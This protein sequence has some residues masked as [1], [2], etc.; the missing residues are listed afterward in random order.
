MWKQKIA[1]LQIPYTH[2][3][4]DDKIVS[5]LKEILSAST[6]FPAHVVTDV[7]GK[8]NSKVI[9]HMGYLNRES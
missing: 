9:G 7:N 3:F 4:I 5:Q 8:I 6:G 2:I 1:G